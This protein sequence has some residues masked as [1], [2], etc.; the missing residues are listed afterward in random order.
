MNKIIAFTS[1]IAALAT[2]V[3]AE[4]YRVT[5]HNLVTGERICG[6]MEDEN[7]NGTVSAQIWDRLATLRAVG[8]WSGQGVAILVREE[9]PVAYRVEVVE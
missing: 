1:I 6:V 9:P 2:S 7:R 5:G 4:E 8:Q 3:A